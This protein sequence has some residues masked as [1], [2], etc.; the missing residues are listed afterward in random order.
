MFR[1]MTFATYYLFRMGN[2]PAAVNVAC[3]AAPS[4]AI[5]ITSSEPL[6]SKSGRADWWWILRW[7]VNWFAKTFGCVMQGWSMCTK[8]YNDSG[9]HSWCDEFVNSFDEDMG[10]PMLTQCTGAR[11]WSAK[12]K[13]ACIHSIGDFLFPG[14][15]T[16]LMNDRASLHSIRKIMLMYRACCLDYVVVWNAECIHGPVPHL[17][18]S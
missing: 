1:K 2:A 17:E 3:S 11:F 7:P 14:E 6:Q 10:R 5:Y 13:R 8:A 15:R 12:T 4:K 18:P 9:R 16:Q